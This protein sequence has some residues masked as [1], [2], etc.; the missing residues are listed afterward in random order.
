[1]FLGQTESLWVNL[2]HRQGFEDKKGEETICT[3][4]SGVCCFLYSPSNVN[5]AV[6]NNSKYTESHLEALAV[7]ICPQSLGGGGEA[8][9]GEQ[10]E[11]LE[12]G[13]SGKQGG[14]P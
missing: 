11:R 6:Q 12:R 5:V 8:V 7:E 4:L 13:G 2:Q 1:M 10:Q 9:K 14:S 3:I